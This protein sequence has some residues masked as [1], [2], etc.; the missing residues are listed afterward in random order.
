MLNNL[1]GQ[2]IIE[3]L[4]SL[5]VFMGLIFLIMISILQFSS[6]YLSDHFV[7]SAAICIAKDEIETCKQ[8]LIKKMR[9]IPFMRFK[10]ISFKKYYNKINVEVDTKSAGGYSNNI[11]ENLELPIKSKH[12]GMAK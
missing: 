4:F 8:Q 1:K 5:P 7:Y 11:R 6:H 9:L 12:F 10:I 3:S 2:A